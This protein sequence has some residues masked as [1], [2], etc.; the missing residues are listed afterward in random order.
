MIIQ[1]FVFEIWSE[2]NEFDHRI[3][4]LLTNSCIIIK[5]GTVRENFSK[6]GIKRFDRDQ[7]TTKEDYKGSVLRV[8][9]F[10]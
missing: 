6:F 10:Y 5:V 1:E 9:H 8:P 3:L 4:A 7:N 2:M